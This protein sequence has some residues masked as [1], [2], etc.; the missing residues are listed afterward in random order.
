MAEDDEEDEDKRSSRFEK[1]RRQGVSRNAGDS[2]GSQAG[3]REIYLF[4]VH[5]GIE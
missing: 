2:S 5:G 1:K 3:E 4:I